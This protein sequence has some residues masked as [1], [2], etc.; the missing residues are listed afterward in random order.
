MKILILS[1]RGTLYSTRRF[2]KAAL[3]LG[4]EVAVVDP[5][6]CYIVIGT[7]GALVFVKDKPLGSPDVVL[8]RIAASITE[9]GLAMVSQLEMAGVPVVNSSQAILDSR[10]KVRALQILGLNGVP[11][12]RTIMSRNVEE[13][14]KVLELVGGPPV[15]VKLI[16]GSQGIGVML[17]DTRESLKGIVDTLWGLGQDILIQEYFPEAQGRDLRVL[18]VGDRI[19][20][21][22]QRVARPGEFRSNIHRGGEG[23]VVPVDEP[24]RDMALRAVRALKLNVAGVDI[25]ESKTGPRVMEV[26]SSPGFEGLERA[27]GLDIASGII[28]FT[29]RYAEEIKERKKAA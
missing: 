9:Y 29:V 5:L 12:P 23:Q 14:E 4:H 7:G 26:N 3:K 16:Q 10:D 19:I 15:I 20:A 25:I 21:A 17:A 6:R 8:P 11:V 13:I 28:E 2:T 24:I 22:M 27:T 1:R 18:V